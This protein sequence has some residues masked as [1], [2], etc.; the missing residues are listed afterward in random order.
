MAVGYKNAPLWDKIEYNLTTPGFAKNELAN[1]YN[2]LINITHLSGKQFVEAYY[3]LDARYEKKYNFEGFNT[4]KI[5]SYAYVAK[6]LMGGIDNMRG[7]VYTRYIYSIRDRAYILALN[8]KKNNLTK[9]DMKKFLSSQPTEF[10]NIFT[11]EPFKWDGES[12]YFFNPKDETIT[13]KVKVF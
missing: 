6:L 12:I 3:E 4:V 5:L 7:L 8:A 10:Q 1:F 13:Y 2:D 11:E 9:S